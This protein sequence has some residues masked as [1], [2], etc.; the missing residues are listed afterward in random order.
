M[1]RGGRRP[2]SILG[3]LTRPSRIGCWLWR[4]ALN[5]QGYGVTRLAGAYIYVHRFMF[6][7]YHGRPVRPGY[8]V[9]HTCETKACANPTHLEEVPAPEHR[10]WNLDW[11]NA[12]R[13][14]DAPLAATVGDSG[15]GDLPW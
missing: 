10:Q 15:D 1:R 5:G 9:H 6:A 7:L 14:T 4:G 2:A 11:W 3:R 13:A 12:R 8:D